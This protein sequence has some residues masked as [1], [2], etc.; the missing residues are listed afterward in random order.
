MTG[1][2]NTFGLIDGTKIELIPPN[3]TLIFRQRFDSVCGDVLLTFLAW[4]HCVAM[5]KT[6]SPT[7]FTSAARNGKKN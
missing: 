3:L 6:V 5:P 2:S 7:R 1:S 4:T